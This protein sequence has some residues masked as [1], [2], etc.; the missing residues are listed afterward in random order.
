LEYTPNGGSLDLRQ[1]IADLFGDAIGAEKILVFAGAQVAIQTAARA[2]LTDNE[3][4]SD[5]NSSTGTAFH[6]ITFTPGYQSVQEG[7]SHS[8]STVTKIRLTAENS[9]QIDVSKPLFK[10][11]RDSTL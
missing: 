5:N 7:P 10:T 4:D 6:S 1:A 9:W 8:G 3:T 2:I 11:K